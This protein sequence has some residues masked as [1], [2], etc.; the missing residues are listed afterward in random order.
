LSVHSTLAPVG[1]DGDHGTFTGS[2]NTSLLTLT[3]GGD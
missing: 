2:F 1:G 3:L